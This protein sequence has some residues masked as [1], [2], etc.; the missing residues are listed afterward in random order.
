[1]RVVYHPAVQRDVNSILRYYETVSSNLADEFWK[2][3]LHFVERLAE[4]PGQS[5]PAAQGLCRVNLRRF[6]YHILFR[7]SPTTI[8]II[9]VRHNKRHPSVGLKRI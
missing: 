9:V 2:E 8:R 6:P 4:N 7:W 5:H 3:L 1:M